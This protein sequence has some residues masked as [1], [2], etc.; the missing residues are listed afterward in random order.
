MFQSCEFNLKVMEIRRKMRQTSVLDEHYFLTFKSTL[1]HK[2][3][4][5]EITSA[6]LLFLIITHSSQF[7]SVWK[8]VWDRTLKETG[9]PNQTTV[10]WEA[11]APVMAVEYCT[12]KPLTD[13]DKLFLKK[14]LPRENFVP[15]IGQHE[16]ALTLRLLEEQKEELPKQSFSFCRWFCTILKLA[17]DIEDIKMYLQKGLICPFSIIESARQKLE[18]QP[19]GTMIMNFFERHLDALKFTWFICKF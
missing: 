3:R 19:E 5:L 12:G 15:G 2:E 14:K 9:V 1:N 10:F 18:T 17:N 4:Q 16:P 11:L 6:S 7:P 8:S 13:E